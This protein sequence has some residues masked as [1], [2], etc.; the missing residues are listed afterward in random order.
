MFVYLF[1][2]SG[3]SLFQEWDT[4][5]LYKADIDHLL[6]QSY[7]SRATSMVGEFQTCL[8]VDHPLNSSIIS[9]LDISRATNYQLLSN[10]DYEMPLPRPGSEYGPDIEHLNV[11]VLPHSHNDPGWLQTVEEYFVY[12]TKDILNNMVNKLNIYPNMTFVWSETVLLSMW[13]NELEDDVKA[14]VRRLVRRGQLEI[15]L[16]GW[17]MP[18]EASTHYISVID[19]LLEGHQWVLEHLRVKP[20]NSWSID[21]FGH[22]GTMP[23]LWKKAGLQNMVIQ[24]IHQAVKATLAQTRNLEFRWKQYWDSKGEN[25]I[26]CHVMPYILYGTKH[27]CGPNSF[28]CSLFDF[29][30]HPSSNARSA[31]KT[32]TKENVGIQAKYLYEQ[33]RRKSTLYK[34]NTILVPLGDDF[35][36]NYPQEWDQQYQNYEYLMSYMN[37]RKD[38]KINVRFGTLKDFFK[39]VRSNEMKISNSNPEMGLRQLSGDFY[40]YSDKNYAYWTGYYTTRPF[41]KRFSRDVESSLRAAD[42]L[43]MFAYSNAKRWNYAYKAYH[44]V[45]NYLQRARQN[46]GLFLHHDGITGTSKEYVVQDYESKLL[47]AYNYTQTAMRLAIQTLLS[48][49]KIQ[50]PNI[51]SMET[52]RSHF[53]AMAIK[54]TIPVLESGTRVVLFNSIGQSRLELISV[55]IDTFQIEIKNRKNEIIPYQINPLWDTS[56]SVHTSLFEVTFFVDLPPFSLETFIFYKLVEKP[57]NLYPA[58]ITIYN[59]KELIIDPVLP[60]Y[61]EKP[62]H[63]EN[64]QGSI[65][66]ENEHILAE[67]SSDNGMLQRI[68]DKVT[69]NVTSVDLEFMFYKSQGSGAYLFHPIP[70]AKSIP[71][72]K[73]VIRVIEGP[74]VS[75]IQLSF[76]AIHHSMRLVHHPGVQGRGLHVQ[77][78]V[79]MQSTEMKDLEIIMRMRTSIENSDMTFF[80]DENGFQLIGRMKNEELRTEA[81]YYPITTMAILED[82]STRLTLHAGQSHGVAS[83]EEGWLEVML[84]RNLVY[85]DER[86]LGEGVSDN[87]LSLSRFVLQVEHKIR[88]SK[89]KQPR[90]TYPSL[91]S[92]MQNKLLQQPVY[93]VFT[94]INTDMLSSSF[95]P[96]SE[97]LPCDVTVVSMKNLVNSDLVYNGTSL[98][99]HKH[100]FQCDYPATALHCST[101]TKLSISKLFQDIPVTEVRE[102]TLTHMYEK[103]VL[104]ADSELKLKPMELSTYKIML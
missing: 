34:Y 35:R 86:G 84:D 47:Y 43:N 70:G 13:W 57:N 44:E 32:I 52:T 10:G 8:E 66:L 61:I 53:Q 79:N 59:S 63:A 38:W 46:L 15:V 92:L 28:V 91:L 25:D 1:F 76:G 77:N 95:Q 27:T 49:G 20:T 2:I 89:N 21:P 87:K 100:G 62:R 94:E 30:Y 16:G 41:D 9:T 69:G 72:N 71:Y 48:K 101:D 55:I 7:Q 29:H 23:Y 56:I 78:I 80:T 42:I 85:D 18:D 82:S 103:S 60:F 51:I 45:S 102:T 58:K 24:R 33:Y 17:V 12:Q 37:S 26:L 39:S 73:P 88:P 90:Y 36:F 104:A 96:L 67:F 4:D 31:A 6:P 98:I 14:Q 68:K 19:Q 75:E 40:P 50:T 97:Q 64:F 93:K 99:L 5:Q 54:Q 3:I 22:S 83:L 74:F 65:S 11:I 81:N